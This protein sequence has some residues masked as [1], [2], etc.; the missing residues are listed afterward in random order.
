MQ[1]VQQQGYEQEA[2]LYMAMELSNS[3]W[4][5]G[6]SSGERIRRKSIEARDRAR[7]IEEVQ[8]AKHK[9]GLEQEAGVVVC[10]EAGRDGHWTCCHTFHNTLVF[11]QALSFASPRGLPQVS[12]RVQSD[13][14]NPSPEVLDPVDLFL[15]AP[16]FDKRLLQGVARVLGVADQ[17]IQCPEQLALV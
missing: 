15:V 13:A 9:L 4:K 6:F 16:T 14:E 3:S 10:F 11:G 7:L 2:V 12:P 1:A 5:L 8:L 17:V